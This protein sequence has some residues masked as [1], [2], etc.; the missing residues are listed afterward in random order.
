MK[1]YQTDD[2]DDYFASLE[3]KITPKQYVVRKNGIVL[4]R[5]MELKNV[6]TFLRSQSPTPID[7]FMKSAYDICEKMG[8]K[9]SKEKVKPS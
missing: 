8:M 1:Y 9:L 4:H 5:C 2:R 6:K 3:R 7:F